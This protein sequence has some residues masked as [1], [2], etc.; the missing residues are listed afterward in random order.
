M[1][2]QQYVDTHIVGTGDATGGLIAG[3]DGS[4]WASSPD[5]QNKVSSEE[6]QGL[7]KAYRDPSDVQVNGAYLAGEKWRV[8]KVS[9]DDGWIHLKKGAQ[10]AHVIKT[11][12]ALLIGFNDGSSDKVTE[13][14]TSTCVQ[15]LGDYLKS[16]GY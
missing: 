6:L 11:D 5:V 12:K 16:Q 14:K 10:S 7:F 1:S 9:P 13:G 4:I 3:H 2:W 15:K 8:V